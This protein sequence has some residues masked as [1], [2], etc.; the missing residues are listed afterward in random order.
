MILGMGSLP[1][2]AI[3][4]LAAPLI[5]NLVGADA[6]GDP[7]ATAVVAVAAPAEALLGV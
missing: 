7:I 1:V 6:I 4:P 5:P 3:I 2:A